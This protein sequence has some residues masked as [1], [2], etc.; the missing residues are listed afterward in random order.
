MGDVCGEHVERI[1]RRCLHVGPQHLA[2]IEG[3]VQPAERIG[4]QTGG[5]LV[6]ARQ[7]APETGVGDL[8]TGEDGDPL[9]EVAG[10]RRVSEPG[11]EIVERVA[12]AVRDVGCEGHVRVRLRPAV[13]PRLPGAGR[14]LLR[15]ALGHEPVLLW[16]LGAGGER[17]VPGRLLDAHDVDI[18]VGQRLR[19]QREAGAEG[20]VAFV[21]VAVEDVERGDLDDAIGRYR[22]GPFDRCR[23]AA[24]RNAVEQGRASGSR[25]AVTASPAMTA[26]VASTRPRLPPITS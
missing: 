5:G 6:G 8:E 19:L 23:G 25:A 2:G 3:R 12:P 18:G 13:L 21:G 16:V 10:I 20:R 7:V 11:R 14:E 9:A 4:V 15:E 1:A 26:T 17:L 22:P 24:E